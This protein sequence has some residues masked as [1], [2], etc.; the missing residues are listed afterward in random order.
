MMDICWQA[1]IQGGWGIRI[2]REDPKDCCSSSILFIESMLVRRS[3]K[4]TQRLSKSKF[5]V[6][7]MKYQH[8]IYDTFVSYSWYVPQSSKH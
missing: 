5:E 1:R 8:L 7:Y 4:T 2:V 6:I 3:M